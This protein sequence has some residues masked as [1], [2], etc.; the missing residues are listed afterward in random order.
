MKPSSSSSSS[1]TPRSPLSC[2]WCGKRGSSGD[3]RPPMSRGRTQRL[4]CLAGGTG[5]APLHLKGRLRHLEGKTIESGAFRG[6]EPSIPAQHPCPA[7]AL[8]SPAGRRR[9][10]P[11]APIPAPT[12]Q[13][14][15]RRSGPAFWLQG[16]NEAGEP[17][18]PWWSGGGAAARRRCPGFPEPLPL[19]GGRRSL[20]S[21]AMAVTCGR[22]LPVLLGG[23][24]RA[25]PRTPLRS[26]ASAA[27]LYDVVVSGGG[28]V[29]SAMAAVLGKAVTSPAPCR[30]AGAEG[31]T[32]CSWS[33]SSES[34]TSAY[35]KRQLCKESPGTE[36]LV[37]VAVL[38]PLNVT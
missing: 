21:A 23:R 6:Y 3:R 19:G 20:P 16:A 7:S 26:A 2:A 27:P 29:G 13:R 12:S 35:P 34:T 36:H 25:G 18:A 14:S 37:C 5:V 32:H 8:G 10:P 33:L 11:A 1:D 31:C 28:M 15:R 30:G 17:V 24:L 4:L 9:S 38:C 22:T